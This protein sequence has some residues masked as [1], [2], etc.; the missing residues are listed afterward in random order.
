MTEIQKSFLNMI[1]EV[2]TVYQN[3]KLWIKQFDAPFCFFIIDAG[4]KYEIYDKN[5]K[6]DKVYSNFSEDSSNKKLYPSDFLGDFPHMILN[7]KC[8]TSVTCLKKG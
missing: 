6:L 2:C 5:G 7:K 4:I 1:L 3:Q 8:T